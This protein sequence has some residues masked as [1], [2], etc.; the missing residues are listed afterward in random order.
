MHRSLLGLLLLLTI[1][2][3]ASVPV[4]LT[5]PNK[6]SL[7][8]SI[9]TVPQIVTVNSMAAIICRMPAEVKQGQYT[10][11][12]VDMFESRGPIDHLEYRREVQISCEGLNIYCGYQEYDKD[13]GWQK[14]VGKTIFIMPLGDCGL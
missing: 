11:G 12:V 7:D 13:A 5:L 1:S 3:G 9:Y 10:F 6:S 8:L 2:C 14:P 4:V